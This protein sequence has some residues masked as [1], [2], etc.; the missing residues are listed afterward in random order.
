MNVPAGG[1]N[2]ITN[3][4]F[5]AENTQWQTNSVW[6]GGG[7]ATRPLFT[8]ATP[9]PTN[10][11]R[12]FATGGD[13]SY[14]VSQIEAFGTVGTATPEPATLVL[15]ATGFAAL[16]ASRQPF[17]I[18]TKDRRTSEDSCR[19]QHGGRRSAPALLLYRR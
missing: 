19:S 10:Q 18:V 4:V 7:M 9:V 15:I 16:V 3:G 8:L 11:L 5:N 14:S 2:R 12:F 17:Q 6:N 1:A 13:N